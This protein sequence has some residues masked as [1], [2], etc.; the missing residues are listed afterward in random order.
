[1]LFQASC[2]AIGGRAVL[3][4]GPPGSG[5]TSL[6]LMLIDRGAELVGDDGVALSVRYDGALWASFPPLIGGKIEIRNIGI[7]EIT[8]TEAPVALILSIDASAPRFV[9]EPLQRDM[10]GQYVPWLKFDVQGPAAPIRAEYALQMHG[11]SFP[12]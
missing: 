6:A 1:M 11:L 2:V 9:E 8:A 4:E 7:A 12:R 5:K 3:I 10:L